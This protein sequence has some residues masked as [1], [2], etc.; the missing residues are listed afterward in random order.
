MPSP[1]CGAGAPRVLT[2]AGKLQK[3]G[4]WSWSLAVTEPSG[5]DPAWPAAW[6]LPRASPGYGEISPSNPGHP[7]R[8][9]SS[10]LKLSCYGTQSCRQGQSEAHKEDNPE[11]RETRLGVMVLS[12]LETRRWT[13]RHWKPG[14]VRAAAALSTAHL[15]DLHC[16]A[17]KA[18]G[19]RGQIW[20]VEVSGVNMSVCFSG[21]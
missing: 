3:E 19:G 14:A 7:A 13:E 21:L 20:E 4:K 6:P 5:R 17:L 16:P 11:G 10:S 2:L 18:G 8:A 12:T 9:N 1:G 15:P